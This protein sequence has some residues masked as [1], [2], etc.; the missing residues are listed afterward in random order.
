MLTETCIVRAPVTQKI[1][2][3]LK[4]LKALKSKSHVKQLITD[5]E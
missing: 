5:K 4:L 2:K 1:A 3:S